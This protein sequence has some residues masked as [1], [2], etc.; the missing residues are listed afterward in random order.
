MIQQ[1]PITP[2]PE[3]VLQWIGE[4]FGCTEGGELGD[5]RARFLTTQAATLGR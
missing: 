4:F 1:H 3:L 5:F 2:P